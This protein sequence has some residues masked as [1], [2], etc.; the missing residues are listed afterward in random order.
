MQLGTLGQIIRE[1]VIPSDMTVSEAARR[2]EV[3]RVALSNLLNGK[4]SLSPKMAL[5]LERTFGA[6][7][8]L[9]GGTSNSSY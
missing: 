7:S 5:K 8:S 3:G 6:V 1:K 2:L 4:A 9:S